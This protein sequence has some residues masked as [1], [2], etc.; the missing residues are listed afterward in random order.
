VRAYI[1]TGNDASKRVFEKL[2]FV[3]VH[4][5]EGGVPRQGKRE[6]EVGTWTMEWRA[7]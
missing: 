3:L 1:L 6:R 5:R 4:T 2:G 7:E